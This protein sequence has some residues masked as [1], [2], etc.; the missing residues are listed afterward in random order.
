VALIYGVHALGENK[1]LPETCRITLRS[2]FLA[3]LLLAPQLAGAQT[4]AG[5]SS[6]PRPL[7]V[8]GSSTIYP[9]MTDI[10]RRFEKLNPGV[11][12][13]VRSGGSGKGIA[14]LRGGVSDI[15]MVS[16]QLADSERHLFAFALCRDGAAIVVHRSNPLKGLSRRQLSELL[17][18]SISDWKQLGAHAGAIKLAW[19]TE[20]QAIPELIQRH[21]KLKPEQIRSH[22]AFFENADAIGFVAND[23]NAVTL[24][25][26][27]VAERSVKSGVAIKLLAYE[28]TPASTRALRERTYMLSRPL[29]LVTRS[30]PED[31]QKRLID[32]AVSRAVNDLHEKHGFVL[33]ED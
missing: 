5:T 9:L 33:Y 22:A 15:A 31:L 29:L 25:A 3:L 27:G 20:N 16:R 19:R 26:L 7:V 2:A 10:A 8:T 13:D 24:A 11:S 18:G 1:H 28:G 32:Y 23:R 4:S 17:T 12:I 21:L 30:L 14:D 6:P